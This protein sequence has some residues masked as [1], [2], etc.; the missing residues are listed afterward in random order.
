MS[1]WGSKIE[2]TVTQEDEHTP[3]SNPAVFAA[4]LERN[5]FILLNTLQIPESLFKHCLCLLSMSRLLSIMLQSFNAVS[6]FFL[7][8]SIR[9]IS[10]SIDFLRFH[11]FSVLLHN[12]SLSCLN[13]VPLGLKSLPQNQRHEPNFTAHPPRSS[14]YGSHSTLSGASLNHA[15][16][17]EARMWACISP[18]EILTTSIAYSRTAPCTHHDLTVICLRPPQP[19]LNKMAR[20]VLASTR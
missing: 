11:L 8:V 13:T 2:W 16:D 10:P 3:P 5:V 18:H 17:G 4:R 7:S 15:L 19:P 1:N 6:E 9:R 14:R 12:N 20:Q